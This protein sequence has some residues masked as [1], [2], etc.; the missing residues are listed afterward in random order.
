MRLKNI[1]D[2]IKNRFPTAEE[3]QAMRDYMGS[4]P[5]RLAAVQAVEAVADEVAQAAVDAMRREYPAFDTHHTNGWD[6]G[7]RDGRFVLALNCQGLLLDDVTYQDRRANLMIR[8]IFA[9]VQMPPHFVRAFFGHIRDELQS[10]L[11]DEHFALLA[12]FLENNIAVLGH[13]PEPALAR[14]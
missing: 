14:Y 8:E 10:R 1:I 13:L 3:E 2:G 6:K 5:T 9:A 7:V 11:S 4:M 12:P